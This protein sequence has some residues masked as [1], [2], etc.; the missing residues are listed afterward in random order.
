M[1]DLEEDVKE[2]EI[3][4]ATKNI[5]NIIGANDD[6]DVADVCNT[7]VRSIVDNLKENGISDMM[8]TL[9]SISQ[10]VGDKIDPNKMK[11]TANTMNGFMQNS[12]NV[13]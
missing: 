8:G 4:D 7:L 12:Q 10:S 11:K 5:T 6:P 13:P 9:Q 2:E 1:K 3:Q